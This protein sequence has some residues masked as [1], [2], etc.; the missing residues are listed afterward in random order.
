M[1]LASAAAFLR[2]LSREL[3]HLR[4]VCHV[5]VAQ[6]H[7]LLVL[8]EVVV[9]LGQ[10]QA[11]LDGG[12]DDH[13]GVLAVFLGAEVEE[14]VRAHR[15]QAA[16]LGAQAR[17]VLDRVDPGELGRN[18]SEAVGLDRRLVHAGAVEVAELALLGS[19]GRGFVG[20]QPLEDRVQVLQVALPQL[21]EGSPARAVRGDRVLL[22]PAAVGVLVEIH[23]GLGAGVHVGDDQGPRARGGGLWRGGRGRGRLGRRR[24]AQD[25]DR[26]GGGGNEA[27]Q[28]LSQNDSH[29]TSSS[30][31]RA[32]EYGVIRL[33]ARRV[34]LRSLTAAESLPRPA[35][36]RSA[37][38]T[39]WRFV[40]GG[41]G[42]P[43]RD[44]PRPAV[45]C[46]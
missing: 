43:C 7:G 9:A 36:C 40:G 12:R 11:G 38:R 14:H 22:Q 34:W 45:A 25:Q 16:D 15:L 13:G 39:A 41:S 37:S 20:G 6:L 4:H 19:G 31:R 44:P 46:R 33:R 42:F 26:R 3:E 29:G 5:L 27:A 32:R 17:H 30:G 18:G 23:A 28:K 2:F 21:V 8:L 24:G 1:A 35:R 10:A